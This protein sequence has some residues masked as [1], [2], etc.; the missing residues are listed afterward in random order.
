MTESQKCLIN[1]AYITILCFNICMIPTVLVMYG[2]IPW[3]V[4]VTD[5]TK[6]ITLDAEVLKV[7]VVL[8]AYCCS[9]RYY[10]GGCNAGDMRTINC[11]NFV[12]RNTTF[13]CCMNSDCCIDGGY[14]GKR[15]G[16]IEICSGYKAKIYSCWKCVKQTIKYKIKYELYKN[17]F[18]KKNVIVSKEL[19]PNEYKKVEVG[20]VVEV[21]F[22]AEDITDK[23]QIEKGNLVMI[24]VIIVGIFMSI[25][26]CIAFAHGRR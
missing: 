6:D 10:C 8:D 26:L 11:N 22:P 20:E 3:L 18:I 24:I 2:V 13:R 1:C 9:T 21:T 12:E 14:G 4:D 5:E 23:T 19:K 17:H 15:V 16:K 7:D 25:L